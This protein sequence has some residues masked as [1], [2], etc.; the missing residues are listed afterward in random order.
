MIRILEANN[1][2]DYEEWLGI[3]NNWKGKEVFAHPDYLLL[4]KEWSEIFCAVYSKDDQM[5]LFPFCRRQIENSSYF[6]IITPYGYADVY[7]LGIGDSK[8]IKQEFH[9][10]FSLWCINNNIVSEFIRFGLFSHHLKDYKG[11]VLQNNDNVVCDLTK[12]ATEV[13]NRFK[14]KVRRNIRKAVTYDLKVEIDASGDHLDSFLN[15]YYK[16]MKR[17]NADEK[18][19]FP[20]EFFES[21]DKKLDGQFMYFFASYEGVDVSAELVLISDDKIYFFLGGTDEEAYYL[22]SSEFLKYE[23]MKWGID[24]KKKYYVLGGGYT[25]DDS[26]FSFKKS[27]APDGCMPYYVGNMI[28]NEKIYQQL[29]DDNNLKVIEKG[30]EIDSNDNYFPLYR[31]GLDSYII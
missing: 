17:R 27:F 28:Y 12:G 18:Y 16:T 2:N 25:R 20:K 15:L 10:Q 4:Y 24:Q 30:L 22:R 9:S 21:I 31:K 26:L 23:I 29:V 11:R 13:W 19:F 6:D 3:W 14:P 5:I 8:L 7:L 1:K